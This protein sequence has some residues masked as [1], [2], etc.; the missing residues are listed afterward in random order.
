MGNALAGTG[1]RAR[2]SSG[3]A[4]HPAT[5][6]GGVDGPSSMHARDLPHGT[7]ALRSRFLKGVGISVWQCSSD[8]GSNWT[9]FA[10]GRW[11]FRHLGVRAVRGGVGTEVVNGFW[12]RRVAGGEWGARPRSKTAKTRFANR[13]GMR[14]IKLYLRT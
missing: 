1:A 11:P 9:R 5:C 7:H 13:S 6:N 14:G 10:R 2:W 12:D 4:Q 3:R 8:G